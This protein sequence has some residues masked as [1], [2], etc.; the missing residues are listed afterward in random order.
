[1][2]ATINHFLLP[3]FLF[4]VYFLGANLVVY[5]L[6]SNQ[7]VTVST[8]STMSDQQV[9]SREFD[10]Q[11]EVFNGQVRF[12][13]V[14]SFET[15]VKSK[16]SETDDPRMPSWGIRDFKAWG[17]EWNKKHPHRKISGI[18]TMTKSEWEAVYQELVLGK[19]AIA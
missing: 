3:I 17:S 12:N 9:F 1:M 14:P 5:H 16:V 8:V 7:D 10:P 11:P 2:T 15:Q 18:G 19:L 13:S 4:L 6:G